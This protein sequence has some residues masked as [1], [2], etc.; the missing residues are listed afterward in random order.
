MPLAPEELKFSAEEAAACVREL[1]APKGRILLLNCTFH[2]IRQIEHPRF[3]RTERGFHGE[4][5]SNLRKILVDEGILRPR[6]P[7]LEQEYQK[8]FDRHGDTQRPDT[9]LHIPARESGLNV[10]EGNIC[11]WALKLES[12]EG[13]AI[14]DFW[15][16]RYM[17]GELRYPMGIFL[18]IGADRTLWHLYEH[19]YKERLHGV[20][21]FID[22]G[23][24]VI[25]HND[26]SGDKRL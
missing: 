11:A 1:S 22:G 7:I 10:N 9:I 15:K 21:C 23:Q 20:A 4:F 16:L 13:E 18:N 8:N 3:W 24:T 26:G 14:D 17:L 25:I 19:D 2:A 12:S 5:H 6:G